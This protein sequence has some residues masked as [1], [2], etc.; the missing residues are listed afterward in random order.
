MLFLNSMNFSMCHIQF[1]GLVTENTR[2]YVSMETLTQ[3]CWQ[4][5]K[6][7]GQEMSFQKRI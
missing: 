4:F 1:V 7:R 3:K 6:P 5:L 2:I